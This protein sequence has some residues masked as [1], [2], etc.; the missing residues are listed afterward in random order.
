MKRRIV[1]GEEKLRVLDDFLAFA[2]S[3]GPNDRQPILLRIAE[4]PIPLN[5]QITLLWLI[6]VTPA[7]EWPGTEAVPA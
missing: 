7:E 2:R 1:T 4:L 6:C 3:H 5:E